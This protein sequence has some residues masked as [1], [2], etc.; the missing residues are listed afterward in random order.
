MD[1][2]MRGREM[3]Q[4]AAAPYWV[5]GS[6]HIVTEEAS[7]LIASASGSQLGP[8]MSGA[9]RIILVIGGQKIVPDLSTVLLSQGSRGSNRG[10]AG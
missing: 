3:C 4:L 1:R 8:I 6:V 7:L 2:E 10:V 9:G 5:V